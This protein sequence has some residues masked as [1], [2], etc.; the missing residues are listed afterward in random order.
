MP[1]SNLL[2]VIFIIQR[3]SETLSI[4]FQGLATPFHRGRV[5][6]SMRR[7]KI[8]SLLSLP[9]QRSE[10]L[11]R[12]DG[13]SMQAR[14]ESEKS[15]ILSLTVLRGQVFQSCH[16]CNRHAPCHRCLGFLG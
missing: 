12:V 14:P 10:K 16:C 11:G 4:L 7:A 3:V 6:D 5:E 8:S 2:C 1:T 15:H 13:R 9:D